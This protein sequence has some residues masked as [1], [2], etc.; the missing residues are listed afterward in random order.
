MDL[1]T[2]DNRD[3]DESGGG[4]TRPLADRVRP[5][6]LDEIFGQD[7]LLASDKLLRRAIEADRLSSIILYG[8]P[9]TGKTTLAEAIARTTQRR[10]EQVSGVMANVATLRKILEGARELRRMRGR[11]TILF[12]DEIHRFNKAQQ[13]VLLPYVEKGDVTLIGATTHNPFFFINSP[14]T[15]RSQI[16]QLRP[17]DTGTMGQVLERA[18]HHPEGLGPLRIEL[19][20]DAREH[21]C[22]ICEG[23]ARRALNALEI[24]A[25][26]TPAGEDGV[27]RLD[28]GVIEDSVQKKAVVYD[29]D[30]DEH[31]DTISAFIKSVRGSDP[32]AA[33]YWLAKML[34]AGEDPRFIARRLIILA[35]EDIGNADPHGLPL[36]VASLNA[37]DFVGMP[38]ARIILSQATTYL[39]TAPKSNAAYRAIEEAGR[40]VEQGNTLPVPDH[41]RD[42]HYRGARELGHEGYKYAHDYEGHFVDQ[43]YVPTSKIYYR[44]SREGREAEI[45]ARMLEWHRARKKTPRKDEPSR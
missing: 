27:R 32:H 36:A 23:D 30:E 12:I 10:F 9:G 18:I 5:D 25:L 40:D 16:F 2:S 44:P 15:S 7:H 21:L 13:D 28:R 42:T 33:V 38:E 31:Y 29:H 1:F 37:V 3:R 17:L 20:D 41:L 24:A 4:R 8:P 11:E 26:T 43:E 19:Q 35:S 34:Y 45:R 39:A 6:T 22:S 14:L